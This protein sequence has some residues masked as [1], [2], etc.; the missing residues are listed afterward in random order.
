MRI[1]ADTSLGVYSIITM[2]LQVPSQHIKETCDPVINELCKPMFFANFMLGRW[3]LAKTR[4]P[5]MI[6]RW[7]LARWR[8]N[9]APCGKGQ[10][11]TCVYM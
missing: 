10:L 8:L 11:K 1:K 9:R 3:C 7:N 2:M 4:S 5:S 6:V